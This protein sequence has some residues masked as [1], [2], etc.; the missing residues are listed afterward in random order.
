MYIYIH[1]CGQLRDIYKRISLSG[2]ALF[3]I[4]RCY[5]IKKLKYHIFIEIG[6]CILNKREIF[7]LNTS[8]N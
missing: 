6:T 4:L 1:L 7:D 2:R 5:Q 8:E 3:S